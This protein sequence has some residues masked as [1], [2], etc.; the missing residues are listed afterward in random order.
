MTHSV[1]FAKAI[2]NEWLRPEDPEAKAVLRVC[3]EKAAG[4]DKVTRAEV[5]PRVFSEFLSCADPTKITG[6]GKRRWNSRNGQETA[7]EFA[8]KS[9]LAVGRERLALDPQF[10]LVLDL[11]GK[12]EIIEFP[13]IVIDALARREVGRFQSFV[14]PVQLFQGQELTPESPAVTFDIVLQ[15]FD[16]WLRGTIDLSL[17]EVGSKAVFVTCG[18]WDCHHVHTQC[19][20]C[21]IPAPP[22]FRRWVNIKRTYTT[23]YGREF[24]G[25]KSMLA[26]LGLLDASGNVKH[27]FHHLGMHDVENISRCLLHLLKEGHE[28]TPNG[29]RLS[30]SSSAGEALHSISAVLG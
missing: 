16:N 20:I 9:L 27:G 13:V 22:A 1:S 25:M 26:L 19:N 8:P 23:I 2:R 15:N 10:L 4:E 5:F 30:S 21:G 18:D 3:A 6:Q 29:S 12:H 11:E 14:R 7:T 28:V 17:D 24:R